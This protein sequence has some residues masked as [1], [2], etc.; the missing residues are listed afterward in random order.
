M[1]QNLRHEKCAKCGK[2]KG[3]I[4]INDDNNISYWICEKCDEKMKWLM[5]IKK[6]DKSCKMCQGYG[7]WPI[8]GLTPMGRM[9]SSE[10][11]YDMIVQCPWCKVGGD[12]KSERYIALKEIKDEEDKK[13]IKVKDI[14]KDEEEKKEKEVK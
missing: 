6:Q 13:I 5:E 7:W 3:V 11:T 9:D 14:F 8:G 12:N 4:P 1:K 10:W 2:G